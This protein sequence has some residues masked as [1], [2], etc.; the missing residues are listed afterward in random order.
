MPHWWNQTLT[1]YR[2][3]IS[4]GEDGRKKQAWKRELLQDC[5]AKKTATQSL[6]GQVIHVNQ[7]IFRIPVSQCLM[8]SEGDI[9]MLGN[10]AAAEPSMDE[11]NTFVLEEVRDNSHLANAHFYGRS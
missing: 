5:F 6:N 7:A 1:L 9:I 8:F 11:G 4:I 2:K 10:I 3:V